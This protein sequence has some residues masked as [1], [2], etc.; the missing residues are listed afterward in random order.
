VALA[1]ELHALFEP[2]RLR[3]FMEDRVYVKGNIFLGVFVRTI[4]EQF[5]LNECFRFLGSSRSRYL[6]FSDRAVIGDFNQCVLVV[7]ALP[8]RSSCSISRVSVLVARKFVISQGT[9]ARVSSNRINTR[10]QIAQSI[11]PRQHPAP[12]VRPTAAYIA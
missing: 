8:R 5:V 7:H 10:Y 1:Q 4:Y 9:H 3:G 11:N 2:D 6:S 12:A